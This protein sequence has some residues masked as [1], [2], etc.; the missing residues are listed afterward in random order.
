[1]PFIFL[2]IMLI[3]LAGALTFFKDCAAALMQD[4]PLV[5]EAIPD[6]FILDV[7]PFSYVKTS[8]ACKY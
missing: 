8:A 5:L 7:F 1:M 2:K 4:I 3:S 6:F